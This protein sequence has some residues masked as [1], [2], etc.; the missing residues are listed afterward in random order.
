[1]SSR[2]STT[3]ALAARPHAAA[4]RGHIDGGGDALLSQGLDHACSLVVG[5]MGLIASLIACRCR[6]ACS[7]VVGDTAAA[8]THGS[9]HGSSLHGDGGLGS[10]A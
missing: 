9:T 3:A 10:L 4:Q 8:V 7:L 1:M 5:D 2:S 6:W